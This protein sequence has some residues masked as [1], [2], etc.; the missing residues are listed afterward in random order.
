MSMF[1]FTA[2]V[3]CLCVGFEDGYAVKLPSL[4]GRHEWLP[5]RNVRLNETLQDWQDSTLAPANQE[6]TV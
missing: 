5:Q 6:F 2:N 1:Y 4:C 3:F